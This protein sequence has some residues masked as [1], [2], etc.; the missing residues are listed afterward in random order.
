MLVPYLCLQDTSVCVVV[1]VK[2]PDDCTLSYLELCFLRLVLITCRILRQHEVRH[3]HHAQ[4]MCPE[5]DIVLS[6]MQHICHMQVLALSWRSALKA[7]FH[8]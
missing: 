6:C 8:A 3:Q 5:S 2:A 7:L 1:Q 4:M